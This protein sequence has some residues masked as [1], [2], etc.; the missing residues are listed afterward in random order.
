M[1]AE[2]SVQEQE[3]YMALGNAI[4]FLTD[5]KLSSSEEEVQQK[6]SWALDNLQ[7]IFSNLEARLNVSVVIE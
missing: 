4:Q 5:A 2:L 7:P 3:L 1:V 6:V